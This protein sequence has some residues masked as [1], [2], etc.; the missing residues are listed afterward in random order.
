MYIPPPPAGSEQEK[1]A[2]PEPALTYP[3]KPVAAPSPPPKARFKFMRSLS[4]FKGKKSDHGVNSKEKTEEHT[5]EPQ[6]WE[7]HW[8]QGEYPFVVLE[9]NRAACAIC[10]M[11]FEEPK[12]IRGV[13]APP[14]EQG[15]PVPIQDS[16]SE[17]LASDQETSS[18]QPNSQ[19]VDIDEENREENLK[20]ED[21]GDGA[22]PLR[23]LAC[24]HVFHVSAQPLLISGLG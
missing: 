3:P 5:G 16:P 19:R 15:N 24:G 6:T 9:G 23:L 2:F 12:R 10:L 21:A 14:N 4:S 17:P 22:Q 18:G 20:L 1:L 11:D 13:P 8:E 7:E